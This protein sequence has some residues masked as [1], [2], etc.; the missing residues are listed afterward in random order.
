MKYKLVKVL[1]VQKNV[2]DVFLRDKIVNNDASMCK[3]HI[4]V[5][6]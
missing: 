3:E 1:I 2:R 5:V 6:Q 4:T